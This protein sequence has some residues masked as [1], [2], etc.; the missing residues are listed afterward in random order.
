ME[1]ALHIWAELLPHV[2]DLHAVISKKYNIKLIIQYHYRIIITFCICTGTCV[3]FLRDYE[4]IYNFQVKPD[5]HT[6][7][8]CGVCD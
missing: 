1:W 6:H 8:R 4:D 3:Q 2:Y 7:I 5:V